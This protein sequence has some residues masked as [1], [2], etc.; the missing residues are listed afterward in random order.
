[1]LALD[2]VDFDVRAGEVHAVMG[3]NGAGKSTLIKAVTGGTTLD[4]GEIEFAGTALQLPSPHAAEGV[5]ISTVY[6]EGHLIPDLSIWENIT[7]GRQQTR[8]GLVRQRPAR[9]RAR[10]ALARLDLDL[11]IERDVRSLSTSHRQ[12]IALARCLDIDARLIVLDEPTASLDAVEVDRF[13]DAL[14]KLRDDGMAIVFVTHFMDQTYA[15][16]DRVTVLRNGRHV[17]TYA[18]SDLE[19]VDLVTH[20]LGGTALPSP[21]LATD[22]AVAETSDRL[23]AQDLVSDRTQGRPMA[24]VSLTIGPGE[25]VGLAGLLGSGRTEVARMLF[26]VDP[27]RDGDV[28]VDGRSA[29][30]GSPRSAMAAGLAYCSEDRHSDGLFPGL[31]VRTNIFIA[32]Q[33]QRGLKARI[34]RAEQERTAHRLI[35]RLRIKVTDLEAPVATLSGGNQQKV[36]LARALALDP[37][38]LILDEPTRGVDIGARAEIESVIGDLATDGMSILVV[39]SE[40]EELTRLCRRIIV[41]RDRRIVGEVTGHPIEEQEVL[42]A[43]AGAAS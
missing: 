12:L 26:G 20:M 9:E 15:L 39:S 3:E 6:Q 16:A 4:H 36:L 30:V 31:T 23:R 40:V 38:V 13:F 43:I 8:W 11:D 2:G 1:M 34:S 21:D 7:L 14:R 42:D 18:V 33:G 28:A 32:L 19:R 22:A 37:K 24:P 10:R 35:K 29:D 27:I 25:V 41:L 17:A 5:G